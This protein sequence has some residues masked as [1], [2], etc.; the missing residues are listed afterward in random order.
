MTDLGNPGGLSRDSGSAD[1]LTGSSDPG[2]SSRQTDDV[3][4]LSI[5]ATSRLVSVPAPTIRSWER[6]YGVP[7]A[8]RSRGGHRRYLPDELTALRQM[9]DEIARGRRAADA[10]AIVRAAAEFPAAHQ[11]LIDDFLQAALRLDPR[12]IEAL[13][14]QAKE[15][16]GLDTAISDV[17]LPAMRQIGNWWGSGRCDVAQEH[18][19]TEAT[20]AWLNRRLYLGPSPWRTETVLLACGPRDWH[21]VG[22]ESMGVLLADRGWPCRLVGASTPAQS[23][24][25]AVRRTSAVAVIV[26]SHLAVAR[27]AAVEALRSAQPAGAAVFYAGNAF[28]SPRS[29]SGVPGTYLDVDLPKAAE[30]VTSALTTGRRSTHHV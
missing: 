5:Q 17:L 25:V 3:R 2:G 18:V 1:G 9:R 15:Q 26:V 28:R 13:L 6:R 10:A 8:S 16:F 11:P 14:E 23:L 4:G 19:A 30:T 24:G 29:R 22:L 21:T 20:R 27:R 7:Q 12:S